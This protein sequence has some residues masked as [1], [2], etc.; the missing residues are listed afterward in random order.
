MVGELQGDL[1]RFRQWTLIQI[2]FEHRLDVAVTHGTCRQR[3]ATGRFE[4]FLSIAFS[5]AHQ[6]KAGVIGLLGMAPAME[7]LL[8]DRGGVAS[9]LLLAQRIMRSGVHSR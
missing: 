7:H 1:G 5:Q 6:S 4:P 2:V 3:S 9:P 8:H